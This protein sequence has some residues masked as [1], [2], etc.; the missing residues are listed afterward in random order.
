MTEDQKAK[1]EL[2]EEHC[3]SLGISLVPFLARYRMEGESVVEVLDR[4][5]AIVEQEQQEEMRG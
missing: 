1:K 3:R 2:L 4:V 5:Y